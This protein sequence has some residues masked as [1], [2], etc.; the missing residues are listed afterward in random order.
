MTRG[1][2]QGLKQSKNS[3]SWPLPA[4]SPQSQIPEERGGGDAAGSL[5]LAI[6]METSS[7]RLRCSAGS[8]PEFVQ[9]ARMN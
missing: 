1:E 9:T 3:P 8:S 7:P 6:A 4:F 2:H 5:G